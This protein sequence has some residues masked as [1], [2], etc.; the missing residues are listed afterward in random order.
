MKANNIILVPETHWDREWYL[1]FQE[2]RAKLVIM[3]DKL[4]TILNYNPD[5][6][7][8]TFDG[9]TIP[10]ED[11]LEVKPDREE[12]IKNYVQEN[13]LSIGPFY[14]LADEFLVSGESLIRNLMIGH[15]I[16]K[17]F[18]NVMKAG[19]IPDPFGHIAQL[20]QILKG[21]E[22]PSVLFWR[23]FGN[24][25]EE[26]N[27]NMEF[28]WESPGKAATLLAIHLISSYGSLA[29]L[30]T[31]KINGIYKRALRSIRRAVSQLEKYTATP[32]ILLNN[33]S[34][35]DEAQPEIP[36][37]I[38]QWNRKNP[39]KKIVQR[40]FEY[41]INRVFEYDPEL[42]NYQ[43]ELRGGRYTHLLSGVLSARMW[44]KQRNTHIE[45]LYQNYTEPLNAITCF[46]DKKG[47]FDYPHDY[48]STGLKWLIKNHPHDSICGCSI[49]RVHEE[50]R[51][52][53][54]WAE[55][56]G[57]EIIKNSV[58]YLSSVIK[59]K[60]ENKDLI[61]LLVY[62]PLPWK[63]KD[64][65]SFNGITQSK[66]RTQFPTDFTLIDNNDNQIEYQGYLI[67]E[68]PRYEQESSISK[69]FTFI[70]EV[71]A[72]GYKTY[73][74]NP[75]QK[76]LD[77]NE[78]ERDLKSNPNNNSI[79]NQ[80]YKIK[81]NNEG[82]IQVLDKETET[83]FNQICFF[84]DKGDW[85]D[86]YDF[87][88][89]N[90][91]QKDKVFTSEN[92]NVINISQLIDGPTHKSIILEINLK[93]PISL[94]KNRERRENIFIDNN[95]KV[96]ISLY[97]GIK[98]IDFKIDVENNSKDHRL[99]VL[100][101][102]NIKSDKVYADGHFYVVP[103]QIELPNGD[104]WVQKPLPTNHQKDF[105]SVSDKN[106]CFS[107]INKGLPEYEPIKN[108]DGTITLAITLLR[109]I[110]WLSRDDFITRNS[111]AGPQLRTPGAQCLGHHTF[112]LSLVIEEGK[113]N[114]LNAKIHKKGKEFNNLLLPLFPS[115]INS[116]LRLMDKIVLN[117]TGILSLYLDS[118]KIE[119]KP[120][121]P[122]NLSFLEID[123]D[124]ILLSALKKAEKGNS[125]IL[126][127]YNISDK[128]QKTILTFFDSINILNVSIVNFL[129]ETPQHHIKAEV[130]KKTNHQIKLNLEPNVIATIK[131]DFELTI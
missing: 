62:N 38:K 131:I 63:R 43:G 103:R 122:P 75:N 46:L 82:I 48:I 104:N 94:T 30:N 69:R 71:P 8:F 29:D 83:W 64:V 76:S 35:H 119:R 17:K 60:G 5:Y 9:Q 114:W 40:D 42:N 15:Q 81:V 91:S 37:I 102:S 70:A 80:F 3:M 72:C 77:L 39:N 118:S 124:S 59:F 85:G 130:E 68:D 14:V 128:K 24:D 54:D 73:Y 50:M 41:Y 117:P 61:P 12:E 36:E 4:L 126:R 25:F 52:R 88:G 123:N 79:E 45:Y 129:E 97:Q 27:L 47:E 127:V 110:E 120:I 89:P 99:R 56:I 33:G 23:G 90:E 121:L 2:F 116:D 13:R 28:N 53:F 96:N 107:V 87:S 101:P 93:L 6:K 16:A 1:S 26:N 10:I 109:C 11:Y 19:Y 65:V 108:E 21:F 111:Y 115:M 113:N 106:S 67:K 44:I 125:L 32:V 74:I 98:R 55:Q 66:D 112:E 34:D 18:G 51:T 20:P 7:N 95:I 78:K 100:F 58:G 57:K 22:I 92:A 84:E 105:V 49:D 31:K 86:E